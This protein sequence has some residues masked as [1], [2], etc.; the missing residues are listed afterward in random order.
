M[1]WKAAAGVLASGG[2]VLLLT[3][4]PFLPG[5]HDPLAVP[6]SM[7][8]RVLG[9]AG[10]LFVPVGV[11]WAFAAGQG[12]PARRPFLCAA[13]AF[14]VGV[15]LV[16]CLSF[17]AFLSAGALL[18]MITGAA[19][20]A[21]M[22]TLATRV[23]RMKV[24]PP[25]RVGVVLWLV[26]LPL[27]VFMLQR[28]LLRPAVEFS[29]SRAIENSA[30]LI[31]DIEAYRLT[32]GHYPPS[33]L[34]VYRDYKPRV[35]GIDRFRYEPHLE[36]FNVLFEQP[37]ASLSVREFVVY[38]PLDQQTATSHAM[39]VLQYTPDELQRARGYFAVHAGPKP[40]WM[41]FLF[42]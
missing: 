28:A 6:L 13:A 41:S 3:L 19:G 17:A 7:M 34:S 9:F 40:H 27:A 15:L 14:M 38:N 37:S 39:D 33:L 23:K 12:A 35:I 26:V 2:V 32:R 22:A 24:A 8:A 29:R 4:L 30:A 5:D 11:V 10:L 25:Q 18:A 20:A 36:T 42:D 1:N 16:V 21:T 31:A